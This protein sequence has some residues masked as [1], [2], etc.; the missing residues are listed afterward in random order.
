VW[1]VSNPALGEISDDGRHLFMAKAAGTVWLT[2]LRGGRSSVCE[3]TI[4]SGDKL[5]NGA[6]RWRNSGWSVIETPP[7]GVRA[8]AGE[9]REQLGGSDPARRGLV[10]TIDPD[11]G[12]TT[13]METPAINDSEIITSV[14]EHTIGGSL[15]VI[16][17]RDGTGSTL[18]RIAPRGRGGPWRYR[19]RGRLSGWIVQDRAGS[20]ALIETRS[21]GFPELVSF[22]GRTGR[23]VTRVG[24]PRGVEIALN[25][26]CVNGSNEVREVPAEL[27][28]TTVLQDGSIL[29]EMLR[30]DDLED[31]EQCA[32]ASGRLR[33]VLELVTITTKGASIQPL[34]SYEETPGSVAPAITMFP[35]TSDR[36]GG[37]LAPWRANL[38][39]G[40][41]DS[42]IV[43]L[44]ATV[45]QEYALP[46][47]GPLFV[48]IQDLAVM[49]DGATLV[50][51]NV[52]T[53]DVKHEQYFPEKGV[54][55]VSNENGTV[56]FVHG[57]KPGVFDQYGRPL[58]PKGSPLR[59]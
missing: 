19:S 47:V 55:I 51:F 4:Y 16:E 15:L 33:R 10:T 34:R 29:F 1:S 45:R 58:P 23:V 26:G 8:N 24:F 44:T 32:R 41:V 52:M 43:H 49:T 20:L 22:D 5:P 57:E 38:S 56:L 6:R 42:K 46:A 17:S 54:R 35:V 40:A 37:L 21:D 14:R 28:P 27:G 13:W 2:A 18:G 11:T 25:V 48:G 39:G 50:S 7:N 30:I 3:I 53:G 12:R 31:H 9:P 59:R 36:H